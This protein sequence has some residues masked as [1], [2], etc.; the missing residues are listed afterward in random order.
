MDTVSTSSIDQFFPEVCE[1]I[2]LEFRPEVISVSNSAEEWQRI[3]E[4]F[5]AKWNMPHCLGVIG[6]KHVSIMQLLKSGSLYYN[7][8]NFFS[9]VLLTIVDANYKFLFIDIG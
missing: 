5:E 6:G 7:Y 1:V 8:K 3:A 4:E 2:I 9:M